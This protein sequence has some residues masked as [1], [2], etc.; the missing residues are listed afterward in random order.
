MLL[1]LNVS[2]FAIIDRINLQLAPGLNAITG[3]TGAGKSIIID[4]L[5]ILLGDKPDPSQVRAGAEQ[6]HIEGVFDLS[7]VSACEEVLGAL[8]EYGITANDG[9]VILSRDLNATGRSISRIN[10]RVVNADF[11][12]DIGRRLVDIHG[13]SE[14]LSLMR[15]GSHIDLLDTFGG[16][17][18]E[19]EQLAGLVGDLRRTRRE[20]DS[21]RLDEREIARRIDLLQYQVEEIAGARL[22]VGEDE[23]IEQEMRVLA[24]AGNL[25][26]LANSAYSS[27]YAG[28][29]GPGGMTQ[30]AVVDLLAAIRRSIEE[31]ASVDRN[32]AGHLSQL[33]EATALLED[34]SIS[35][36]T[37]RDNIESDPARLEK[38]D[39]R[40]N[41]IKDLQRKYGR[42][43]AE[44]ITFGGQAAREL[45]SISRNEEMVTELEE[46][47]R[48]LL[49]RIA[50]LSAALSSRR[51]ECAARLSAAIDQSLA[52]LS[53]GG[54]HFDVSITCRPDADGVEVNGE[55]TAFDARGVDKV[56]F[57]VATNTGEPLRPLVKVASGG[58]TSR[59]MLALKSVLSAADATPT[60]VF[61]EVDV[62]VGGRS[63]Q[64]V[65]EKLCSLSGVHQVVVITHLPQIAAF[66]DAHFQI[67]KIVRDNRTVT[68]V[69][70]LDVDARLGELGAMLDGTPDNELSIESAR[71]ML[72]RAQ[73]WKTR[74]K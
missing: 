17:G 67:R 46:R 63:G 35:L 61:D 27:L 47:E 36:R 13:Q 48:D 31:M 55:K 44:V 24:S 74:H 50:N 40:L 12:Q 66:G 29:E 70:P 34:L 19:R 15:V 62:G 73:A 8:E 10:G 68:E 33:E 6:A 39:D 51:R 3:E 58:E 4:A 14:H 71:Q 52:D 38:L 5:G 26:A 25:A 21:L 65:G 53:M 28:G 45:D 59:L 32:A 23:E 60:L 54:T 7:G 64:V 2:N 43:I 9:L 41:T 49:A 1:E 57:M 37:Y 30:T 11:L 18:P 42:T 16:F 20:L 72:D 56:E 69:V 22:R